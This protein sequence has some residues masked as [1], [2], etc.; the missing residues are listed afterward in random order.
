MTTITREQFDELKT[1]ALQLDCDT[2][3]KILHK[4]NIQVEPELPKPKPKPK[5]DQLCKFTCLDYSKLGLF[6]GIVDENFVRCDS[7]NTWTN[8]EPLFN[9]PEPIKEGE[10]KIDDNYFIANLA[11]YVSSIRFCD[12]L[13]DAQIIASNNAYSTRK[14]A[15]KVADAMPEIMKLVRGQ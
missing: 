8:C 13:I 10:L 15:Q 5:M 3:E 7:G 6:K 14:D 9:L 1:I 4:L 2:Y 12:S 11:G